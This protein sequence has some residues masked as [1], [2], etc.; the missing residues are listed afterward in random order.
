MVYQ[1]QKGK[2]TFLGSSVF[3]GYGKTPCNVTKVLSAYASDFL[4]NQNKLFE[5]FG[6]LLWASSFFFF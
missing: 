6:L 2:L 3:E 1:K 5:V 4:C